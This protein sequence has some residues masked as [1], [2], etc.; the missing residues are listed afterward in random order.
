MEDKIHRSSLWKRDID[1]LTQKNK[2]SIDDNVKPWYIIS[3]ESTFANLWNKFMTLV[4]I[5][6]A[7]VTPYRVSFI[8]V[9]SEDWV[10]VENFVTGL[11]LIDFCFTCF[12]A[13]YNTEK[14]L[15]VSLK[16]ILANYACGWMIP[17]IIACIPIN[18]IIDG[19]KNYN[20]LIRVARI[21]RLYRLF[22]ITKLLRLGKVLKHKNKT[23]RYLSYILRISAAFERIFWFA[24]IYILLIHIVSC[25]WVFVG[26]YDTTSVNWIDYGGFTEYDNVSLYVVS[27]YWAFTTFTTVG[28]G[29][30]LAVNST[31]KLFTVIVMTIGIVFYSYTIS[32]I[33]N[34]L[35]NIDTR[36]AKLKNQIMTLD[37]ITSEYSINRKFYLEIS[38][39]LE[40]VSD[41]ARHGVEEFINDLPGSLGNQVL[42]VTYE[43]ILSGNAFFEKKSTEFVAWV[44]LR[45]KF[46]KMNS[47]E[48]VYLEG[49]YASQMYFISVGSVEFVIIKDNMDFPYIEMEKGYYFGETDLLFSENKTHLHSTKTSNSCEFLTLSNEH[50]YLMLRSYQDQAIRICQKAEERLE[51]LNIQESE[52]ESRYRSS[53]PIDKRRTYPK[54]TQL[55]NK[56][57]LKRIVDSQSSGSLKAPEPN[58]LFKKIVNSKLKTTE[59]DGKVARDHVKELE[60]EVYDLRET[61]ENLQNIIEKKY[62][63]FVKKLTSHSLNTS[64]AN[65]SSFE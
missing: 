58:N 18:Y 26:F 62:P 27:I 23:M 54:M 39:A 60:V 40:F 22:K 17:D 45:L 65:S 56:D 32:S 21:P 25:L 41:R 52:A 14:T 6:T 37:S 19:N 10:Y 35:S 12:L 33:T 28:Y 51:R 36:Q 1:R 15:I 7:I 24:L 57:R 59:I 61:L 9:D 44:A 11:F 4:L 46:C 3:P 29:D 43:K 42:I 38:K 49:E 5:Y 48:I 64:S 30:V 55:F 34:V 47:E 50:F 16:K 20:S 63:K 13:Y 31:E 8:E 2:R 53:F